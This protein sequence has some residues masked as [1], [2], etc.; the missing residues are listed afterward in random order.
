MA[1]TFTQSYFHLVFSPQNRYALIGKTWSEELDKYITGIVQNNGHKM[2]AIK[3]MPDH[4]HIFLGYNL[5]QTIPNLVEQI[6]TSSNHWIKTKQFSRF[7]F[8]WQKGYGA[9]THAHSQLN[10]VISY[11]NNQEEHHKK[12]TFRQEYINLLKKYDIQFKDQYL[13]DFFD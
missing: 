8:A 9:I 11:V 2:L 7:R 12:N 6:K 10:A 4:I 1:N 13:F 3:S 5:N